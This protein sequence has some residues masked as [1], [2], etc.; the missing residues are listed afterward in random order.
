M[1]AVSLCVCACACA[2]NGHLDETETQPEGVV[3]DEQFYKAA[4]ISALKGKKIGITVQYLQNAYWAGV[5]TALE[6]VLDGAGAEYT[7]VSC[8]DSAATQIAQIEAFMASKCDLIMVHP[9]EASALENV[10]KDAREA[11]IKVMC[12]DN[13]MEN[14]D[15]N[16]ILDNTK[17]GYAIGKLA[18]DFI[19]EHF[20]SSNPAE[21]VVI[22][23]PKTKV[24]YERENGIISAIK[25][26]SPDNSKIV[27]Q[28]SGIIASEAQTSVETILQANPNVK[29][30][31]GVGAGAM[32]G[33]D[34]AL[35]IF[36]NGKIPEDMGV[37]STDV[38]KQQLEQLDDESYP[39]K[40]IVGFEGSDVDTAVACADMFA[41]IVDGKIPS[42][43]V[44]RA[45]S[46]ITEANAKT[47]YNEMK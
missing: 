8:N 14:T 1:L 16:W 45:F 5:M 44:F 38:T 22:G 31:V 18:S 41:M 28:Q 23:D 40:G 42:H 33:G 2:Q 46:K 15:A 30:V 9:S 11:G 35:K 32:I 19:N 27:A 4:D 36:T 47:I 29:I 7:I 17:L 10:C 13:A 39:A 25:E 6:D 43:N 24:L 21:I 3:A 12:W 34:E 37:F 20:T 26:L